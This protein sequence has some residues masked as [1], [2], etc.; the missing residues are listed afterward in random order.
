[1]LKDN[2]TKSNAGFY[3][4]NYHEFCGELDW[5]C[6]NKQEYEIM[7]ENAKEYVL[8]NYQ[9]DVILNR[10]TSLINGI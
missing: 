2:C 5:L 10:I 9:W 3:F 7:C 1:M 8:A 4:M 6:Q